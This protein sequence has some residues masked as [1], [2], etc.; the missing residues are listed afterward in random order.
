LFNQAR[1]AAHHDTTNHVRDEYAL[2]PPTERPL[3]SMFNP[4]RSCSTQMKVTAATLW[5][6]N[7]G[8]AGFQF[9]PSF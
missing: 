5:I 1:P 8:S 4:I 7:E 9:A 6:D 2:V 3:T